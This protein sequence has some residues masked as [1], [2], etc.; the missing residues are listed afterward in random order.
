MAK[1][2]DP[3]FKVN[4][5]LRTQEDVIALREALADGIIDVVATDHAPHPQEDKDCEWSAAAFGMVGLETAFSILVTTMIETGLMGWDRMIE[6]L[7]TAPAKIAGYSD[8]G[9]SI[10]VGA[11]A[12]LVIVDPKAEWVVD[13]EMMASKSRNTPFHGMSLRGEVVHTIYRGAVVLQDRKLT[14]AVHG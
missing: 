13:R 9:Q 12:N 1:S 3:I 4:P 14:G 11:F 8:Q 6:V 7:S 2:Y 5:P 10:E